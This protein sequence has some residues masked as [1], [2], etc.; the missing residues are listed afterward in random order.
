MGF[1][2]FSFYLE[3]TPGAFFWLGGKNEAKNII[4]LAHNPK[5]NFGEETMKTGIVIMAGTVLRFLLE[6]K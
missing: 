6:N 2:D 5:Y 3:K 1:E 4:P